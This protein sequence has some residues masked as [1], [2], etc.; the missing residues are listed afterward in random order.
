MSLTKYL[1]L[2][3]SLGRM[4]RAGKR[5][6]IPDHVAPLLQRIG[7]DSSDLLEAVSGRARIES[8]FAATERQGNPFRP[9]AIQ[10]SS[11]TAI[12]L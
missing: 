5:G 1:D 7:C 10:A 2:V 3:E 4:V 11:Q 6:S 9:F 8:Y 12:R